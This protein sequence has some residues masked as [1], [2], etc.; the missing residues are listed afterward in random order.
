MGTNEAWMRSG[1]GTV[2]LRSVLA[3]S[4]TQQ[5][6]TNDQHQDESHACCRIFLLANEWLGAGGFSCF[7]RSIMIS[8]RQDFVT[9]DGKAEEW[10]VIIDGKG[11][12]I[13]S[14]KLDRDHEVVNLGKSV[15]LRIF[16][17]SRKKDDK[18]GGEEE[19]EE[20]GKDNTL[21][22]SLQAN[23]KCNHA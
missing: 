10:L 2:Q 19:E 3:P 7:P 21:Y 16:S 4:G 11:G 15:L 23:G 12:I 14:E 9:I 8:N 6:T 22:D 5:G 13:I 20:E 17:I 1:A 18:G